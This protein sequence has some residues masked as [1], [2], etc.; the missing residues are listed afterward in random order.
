MIKAYC[1]TPKVLEAL[2][3]LHPKYVCCGGDHTAFLMEDGGVFTCGFGEE[4]QLGHGN[5]QSISAPRKVME[6]MGSTVCQLSC[7]EFHTAVLEMNKGQVYCFGSNSHGQIGIGKSANLCTTPM[8]VHSIFSPGKG[9]PVDRDDRVVRKL[10]AKGN[11]TFVILKNQIQ[12]VESVCDYRADPVDSLPLCVSVDRVQDSMAGGDLLKSFDAVMM[13]PSCVNGSFLVHNYHMMSHEKSCVDL[14]AGE[15][16][17]EAVIHHL[18]PVKALQQCDRWFSKLLQDIPEYFVDHECLRVYLILTTSPIFNL[19]LINSNFDLI[20]EPFT[21][22]CQQFISCHLRVRQ[23]VGS[24]FV[25]SVNDHFEQMVVVVAS[26]LNQALLTTGK[27]INGQV[28]MSDKKML[29]LYKVLQFGLPFL[30]LFHLVRQRHH[31]AE[32]TMFY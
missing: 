14:T 16:A 4:G 25:S 6:L 3:N 22:F 2:R 27:H 21:R 5:T 18:G 10:V 7:G 31:S 15:K 11:H 9:T 26:I 28:S 23:V 24:W 17:F 29:S 20:L 8:L 13:S 30:G 1:P 12:S 19:K 32:Y